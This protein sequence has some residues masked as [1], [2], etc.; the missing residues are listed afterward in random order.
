MEISG[1]HTPKIRLGKSN[2]NVSYIQNNSLVHSIKRRKSFIPFYHNDFE[3]LTKGLKPIKK[4]CKRNISEALLSH[5]K[6]I[7]NGSKSNKIQKNEEK[8]NDSFSNFINNI[9]MKECHLNKKTSVNSPKKQINK[10]KRYYISNKTL[11]NPQDRRRSA[12]NSY[13]G[14]SQLTKEKNIDKFKIDTSKEDRLTIT[15]NYKSS[16]INKKLLGRIDNLLHKKNYQ[17][18]KKK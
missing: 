3:N 7:V 10:N 2:Q 9:Y 6:K 15:S 18:K 5:D 4:T 16:L 8:K 11:Y 14:L 1:H 13:S 12:I 17:T